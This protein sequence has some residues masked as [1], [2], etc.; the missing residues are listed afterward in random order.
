MG[1]L[2]AHLGVSGD[3]ERFAEGALPVYAVGDGHVLKLFPTVH[4]DE[5]ATERDVLAAVQ[6]RLP[7]PTPRL[8]GAG[9]FGGGGYVLMERLRGESLKDVWPRLG[10]NARQDVSRQ[11]GEALS[12]LHMIVPPKLEPEDWAGFVRTQRDGCVERQRT[13][14]LGA[15]WLEQIPDFLDG[16]D[17]G[18]PE[19]VLA[20]TEVMSAHLL[21]D[22]GR[23]T[24]LFDFEPAMHAAREYEFVATGVF[25][26]RGDRKDNRALHNG[27]GRTVDPRKV[28]AY[29]LLHVYSNLP[30][31]LRELPTEARTLD[32]LAEHWFG[33]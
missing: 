4:M 15:E 26:T 16:V 11:V 5:V 23:L 24:G 7:V 1:A 10:E 13:R 19:L 31:Y 18:R 20:H 25:L 6:G 33:H 3:V 17:L 9:E 14:G 30:W 29:T 8:Y 22:G 27:Y 32:E 2:C 12:A 21:I 28:L